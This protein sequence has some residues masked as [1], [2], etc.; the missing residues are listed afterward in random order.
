LS[1]VFI[2]FCKNIKKILSKMIKKRVE[3]FNAL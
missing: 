3:N 1:S 2:H